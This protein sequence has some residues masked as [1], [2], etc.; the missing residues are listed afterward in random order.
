MLL[1]IIVAFACD[2]GILQNSLLLKKEQSDIRLSRQAFTLPGDLSQNSI[3]LI[4][5]VP[6]N[7]LRE[8]LA[9]P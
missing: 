1:I 4:A 9:H 7:P 2:P 8:D 5:K 6:L 3:S